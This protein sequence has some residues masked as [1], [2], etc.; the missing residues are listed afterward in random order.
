MDYNIKLTPDDWNNIEY[1]VGGGPYLV[2]EGKIYI[3]R[4]KFSRSFLWHKAPSAS[5]I[6]KKWKFN[7]CNY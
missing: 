2:K 4:Q 6:Y 1:A 3:D 5:G 7:T